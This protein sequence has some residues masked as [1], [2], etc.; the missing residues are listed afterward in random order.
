IQALHDDVKAVYCV[1]DMLTFEAVILGEG[2]GPGSYTYEWEVVGNA[3]IQLSG[4]NDLSQV[5][6][7]VTGSQ[8]T[9]TLKLTITR[10]GCSDDIAFND[11]QIHLTNLNTYSP[12]PSVSLD[13]ATCGGFP[14]DL[15]WSVMLTANPPGDYTTVWTGGNISFTN[16]SN[17]ADPNTTNYG[18]QFVPTSANNPYVAVAVYNECG[19]GNS[20]SLSLD[21]DECDDDVIFTRRANPNAQDAPVFRSLAIDKGESILVNQAAHQNASVRII[22]MMGQE[23]LRHNVSTPQKINTESFERGIYLIQLTQAATELGLTKVLVR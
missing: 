13:L 5:N 8:S 2:K 16:P 14:A 6:V 22:N 10:Q 21:P 1:G 12:P 4:Q 17:P 20:V 23:I 18:V 3:G 11:E 19:A 9:N 15:D 7:L